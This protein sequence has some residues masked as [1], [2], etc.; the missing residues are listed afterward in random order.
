MI[1]TSFFAN[2]EVNCYNKGNKLVKSI[3]IGNCFSAQG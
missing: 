1:K 2:T 3:D